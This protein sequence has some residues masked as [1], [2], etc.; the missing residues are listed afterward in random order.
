MLDQFPVT[1]Y[2]DCSQRLFDLLAKT[3]ERILLSNGLTDLVMLYMRLLRG[4]IRKTSSPV[5][6]LLLSHKARD[7][8]FI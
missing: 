5:L 3:R 2:S 4:S 6:V 8:G 1:S 7:V